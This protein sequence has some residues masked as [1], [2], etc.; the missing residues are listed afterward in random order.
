VDWHA[1][2]DTC[3]AA[4]TPA[5]LQQLAQALEVPAA[6]LQELGVGWHTKSNAWAY[7]ERNGN[8]NVIGMGLRYEDGRKSSVHGSSRGLYIPSYFAERPEPILVVE[9]PS[10]VAAAVAMG[11]AV[12]GRPSA[13]GGVRDLVEL[14]RHDERR[15]I[16]MGENDAQ[17]DG[18][19]PGRDG[20]WHVA[21]EL[22][23][24]LGRDTERSLPPNMSKDLR[25][26]Y[27]SKQGAK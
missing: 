9:G 27:I 24:Q 17:P 16:V 12:V 5:L 22:A 2:H 7:P 14:L 20:A 19:W 13:S 23:N 4:L 26:H 15:I 6:A 3:V 11:F 25:E 1:V 18:S 8:G 10:D 21:Q